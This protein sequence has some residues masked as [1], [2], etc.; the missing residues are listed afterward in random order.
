MKK[1]LTILFAVALGLNLSAQVPDYVPTE[2]LVAWYPFNGNANDESGNGLNGSVNGAVLTSDRHGLGESAFYFEGIFPQFIALPELDANL[3]QAGSQISVSLWFKPE[4]NPIVGSGQLIHASHQGYPEIFAR[5]EATQSESIKIYHRNAATNNEPIGGFSPFGE[6][7]F[8][9]ALIDQQYGSYNLWLNGELLESIDFSFDASESYFS[10]G[11]S[12][13]IGAISEAANYHQYKGT[14]DDIAVHNR[15]LTEAEIQGL[16]MAESPTVGCTDPT[17]CNF[18]AEAT[19]DDGSC[20]PSGCMETDACNY[21]ALAECEGEACDYSCCPGPGCCGE[22][23][24]WN[25]L[26]QTCE[27][28]PCETILDPLACGLGTYWDET[29]SQCLPLLTCQEDLDGDGVIGINDLM[30]L[31]SSFGTMCEEPETAEFSCGDPM[32]YHGYDYATVQIGDQCW[33]RENLRNEHYAN[34]DAIPGDLSNSEW[35]STTEGAQAIYNNDASNLVDY[36]RLYNWYAVD[37]ARGLCPTGWHVPTDGDFMTL[38]VEL[39]LSEAEANS[40]GWRGSNQGYRMK[41]SIFWDGSN[42]TGFSMLHGGLRNPNGEFGFENNS[43]L[44]WSKSITANSGISRAFGT[45][46]DSINKDSDHKNRGFSVRCLKDTE[47]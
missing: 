27:S 45:G 17:A 7:S 35:E 43:G 32:N 15:I 21:N 13:E 30:Q 38:E 34:G 25:S 41:S 12:W 20:I 3:G 24:T 10:E 4:I 29:V 39:G 22:G 6:W 5:I 37:D 28:I 11:R 18:D 19:S 40:F 33:F 14:I 2:G 47:E 46:Y 23:T 8:L 42:T 9:C 31:L 44:V 16:Y 36:G 26:E 1:L